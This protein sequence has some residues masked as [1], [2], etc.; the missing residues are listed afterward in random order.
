[1]LTFPSVSPS[2]F[3]AAVADGD[4]LEMRVAR[5]RGELDGVI[6]PLLTRAREPAS[7]DA[8]SVVGAAVSVL[9]S[10]VLLRAEAAPPDDT[11]IER[12][13]SLNSAVAADTTIPRRSEICNR[14]HMLI[15]TLVLLKETK[16]SPTVAPASPVC[17]GPSSPAMTQRRPPPPPPQEPRSPGYDLL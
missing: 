7:T 2:I 17:A 4:S 11:L 15:G 5:L 3:E 13:V 1:M 10:D 9:A 14:L 16:V 8:D 12:L 6:A